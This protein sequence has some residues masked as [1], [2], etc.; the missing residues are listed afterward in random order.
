MSLI[1]IT[2]PTTEPVTLEK[3][4]ESLRM[5]GTESDNTITDLI[6]AAREA[7]E[8]FQN[9]AYFTQTWELSF[10][11]L[12]SMPLTI[13]MPPLQSLTSVKLYDENGTEVSMNI[14]DFILDKRSEPGRIAFKKDKA[15]PS[16]KLQSIDAVVF[17]FVAGYSDMSKVPEKVKQAIELYSTYFYDHPDAEEPPEAFYNLLWPDRLVPV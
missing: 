6:K 15:W 9:K 2:G 4:K 13:P 14:D 16:I 12:P 1:R 10:D 3:M 7:A 11:S 8:E 17:Q 5:D